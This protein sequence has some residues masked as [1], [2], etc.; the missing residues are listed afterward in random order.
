[1]STPAGTILTP[2]GWVVGSIEIADGRIATVRGRALEEDDTPEPPFIL[3]GFIDLHVHGGAGADCMGGEASLRKMLRYHAARGT[4]AMAPTTITAEP[5]AIRAALAD[6]AAASIRSG[7]G[8]PVVLGAHLEGPF[9]NPDQL[10]AQP[11]LTRAGDAALAD[12]WATQCPI[13]VATVA[14]EITGGL[15]VVRA[16]TRHG[17]RVQIGHSRAS[18]A[19]AAAA[20]ACGC[21]GFTHLFNAMS[22]VHH[23][24]QGVTR[25]ALAHADYA[26]L[27]CDLC[28]VHE[29]AVRAARRAIP[30]LYAITDASSAAG[31]ADGEHRFAGRRVIKHGPL[32]T[33]ENGTTLAGSAI[34]MSDA[35]R[36]LAKIGVPLPE[37]SRM[38]ATRQAD[39]LGLSELGRIVAGA[40]AGL[41]R[42]GEH[43][44]VQAVWIDGEAIDAVD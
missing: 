32:V 16:L 38:T 7:P 12:A 18:D 30:R 19:E 22:G 11:P 3:P 40:R 6:I 31:L 39:Y 28:H 23:R 20:F 17:C 13:R 25:Y 10:G 27:I 29:T 42:L 14:P 26:E 34:T 15:D 37:A 1:M 5:N 44:D 35:F 43:L 36:N 33:L 4:V 9:I 8:E 21:T 2:G 41:V 24:E